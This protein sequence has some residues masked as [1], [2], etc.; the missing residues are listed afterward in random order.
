MADEGLFVIG[1]GH[2]VSIGAEGGGVVE[3]GAGA[4]TGKGTVSGFCSETGTG[5][6]ESG[7]LQPGGGGALT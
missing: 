7:G 6:A 4:I 5:L 1:A 3:A 2:G